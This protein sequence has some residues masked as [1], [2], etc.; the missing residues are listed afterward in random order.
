MERHV[1]REHVDEAI[2]QGRLIP[3]E[4][5]YTTQTALEREKRILRIEREGRDR[6]IPFFSRDVLTPRIAQQ[7]HDGST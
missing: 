5:R 4:R 3:A 7:S 1:A 6:L 2:A